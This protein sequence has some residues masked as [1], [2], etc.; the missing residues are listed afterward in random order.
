VEKR[1]SA[2]VVIYAADAGELATLEES[3]EIIKAL[4]N[5]DPLTVKDKGDKPAKSASAVV[6]AATLYVPLGTLID[7]KKT[8]AKLIEQKQAVEKEVAKLKETLDNP[9]FVNRAPADKV[10][11]QRAALAEAQ[12]KL[13][14]L[15]AQLRLLEDVS[16]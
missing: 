14:T 3:V 5:V 6:S 12:A 4:A 15:N 2:E 13:D 16:D 9:N 7:I 10:A 8:G 1:A 11:A